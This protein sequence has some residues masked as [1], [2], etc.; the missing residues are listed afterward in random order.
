MEGAQRA[1]LKI[2]R[3]LTETRGEKYLVKEDVY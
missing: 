2:P 3:E 1:G